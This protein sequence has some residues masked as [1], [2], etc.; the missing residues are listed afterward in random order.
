[1]PPLRSAAL[2]GQPTQAPWKRTC[3][4]PD[5]GIVYNYNGNSAVGGGRPPL[6]AAALACGLGTGKFTQAIAI[7]TGK[8]FWPAKTKTMLKPLLEKYL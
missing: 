5:G 2:E 3:T 4:T 7:M 8:K 6:T 1:M